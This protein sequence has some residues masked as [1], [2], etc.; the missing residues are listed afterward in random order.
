MGHDDLRRPRPGVSRTVLARRR[1]VQAGVRR[2]MNI[3]LRRIF[4]CPFR[5]CGGTVEGDSRVIWWQCA[6]CGKRKHSTPRR[7]S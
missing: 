2:T 7:A 5:M 4:V 3:L 6:T 1:L